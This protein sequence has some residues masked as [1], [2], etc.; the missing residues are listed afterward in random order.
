MIR[1]MPPTVPCPR[2]EGGYFKPL[3]SGPWDRPVPCPSCNGTGI[4]G[5]P[6]ILVIILIL[7][8]LFMVFGIYWLFIK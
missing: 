8:A 5:D 4:D 7:W 1:F 2:C 3:D 6:R